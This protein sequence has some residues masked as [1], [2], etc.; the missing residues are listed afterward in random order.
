MIII[1]IV[2]NGFQNNRFAYVE[3]C[4]TALQ[5]QWKTTNNDTKKMNVNYRGIS[6]LENKNMPFPSGVYTGLQ[7]REREVAK[8]RK[9]VL[10]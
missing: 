4:T 8:K 7:R 1:V 5:F 3:I 2:A 6:H 10:S 9:E